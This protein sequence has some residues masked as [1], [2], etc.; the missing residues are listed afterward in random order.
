MINT[1]FL[2]YSPVNIG[3]RS[4]SDIMIQCQVQDEGYQEKHFE[5][6]NGVQ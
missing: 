6:N 5:Q 2:M 1:D 4:I 3:T